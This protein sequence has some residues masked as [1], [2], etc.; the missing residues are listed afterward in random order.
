[1]G[2]SIITRWF[3][4]TFCERHPVAYRGCYHMLT[5]TPLEGYIATCAAIRDANLTHAAQAITAPTL[6]VC[7]AQD[8]ATPPEQ[9]LIVADTLPNGRFT[10][11]EQAGHLPCIEQ[12]EVLADVVQR[13]LEEQGCVRST[14]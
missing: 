6:V 5:R 10:V 2:E 4:P 12:P 13:F 7:G 8:I 1:V 14:L 9:G 3:A 11:I